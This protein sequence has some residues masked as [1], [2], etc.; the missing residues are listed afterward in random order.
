VIRGVGVDLVEVER[1]RRALARWGGRFLE[2]IYTPEEL[3]DARRGSDFAASL[4]ARFAAK[5]AAYKAA[6]QILGR[7]LVLRS[8]VVS[9][10]RGRAPAIVLADAAGTPPLAWWCSLS[11]A[12]GLACAVVV[13]EEDRTAP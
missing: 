12:G 8:I 13:V 2:R 4:A 1:V 7:P 6:H 10:G 9:A 5:E 3:E 11:H